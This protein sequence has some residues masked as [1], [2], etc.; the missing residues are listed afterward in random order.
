MDADDLIR[1][2]EDLDRAI[3]E[4]IRVHGEEV[5]EAALSVLVSDLDERILH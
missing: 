3:D 4:L 1:A 2:L 5:T